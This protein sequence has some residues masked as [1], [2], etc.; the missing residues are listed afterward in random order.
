MSAFPTRV[1]QIE[2]D[3]FEYLYMQDRCSKS[4]PTLSAVYCLVD[5]LID[6]PYR[7]Q[8]KVLYVGKTTNISS[9]LKYPHPIEVRTNETLWAYVLI[10]DDIDRLEVEFIRRYRPLLN[11][12]YNGS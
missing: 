4:L 3:G 6:C 12:Q 8:I 1:E 5:W 10:T 7:E 11:K 2:L 9:R